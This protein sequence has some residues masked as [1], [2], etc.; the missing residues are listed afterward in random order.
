[1]K[2]VPEE[3]QRQLKTIIDSFDR[4][5]QSVRERQ[6]R[7][8]KKLKLYW[9]GFQR[10]W[11]D[12]SSGDWRVWDDAAAQSDTNDAAYY[13]KPVNVFRA[14]L[15]SIIAALSINLPSVRC[16]PDDADNPLDISTAKAG[17]KIYELVS[18]HNN[19]PLLWLQALYIYCTEGLVFAYN[20][21]KEDKKFGT[22][23]SP[24]YKDEEVNGYYC[25]TCN[26]KIENEVIE[27]NPVNEL[28]MIEEKECPECGSILDPSIEK[29]SIIVSSLV[30]VTENPKSRQF[31]EVYGGLFVKTPTY[32][33][34]QEDMPYLCYSY[35]THYSNVIER[36]PHL[37]DKLG[38]T[39]QPSS[40]GYDSY[41]RWGRLS[42]QYNGEFPQDMVTVRNWWFRPSAFNVLKDERET[43]DLKKRFSKG[44]K[45]VFIND[46][47]AECEEEDL[48]DCWTLLVNPLSDYIQFDPL[49]LLLVSIQDI[50]ND[51]LSL[52]LQTIEQGIP[53]TFADPQVLDFDAYRQQEAT[54]GSVYPTKPVS[55]NK[56]IGESFT[57]LKTATLSQEVMPFGQQV[58]GL[59]QLTSGALPSLFGGESSAGS[60]TAS[61][62]AMSRS[63][64]LQRLQNTWKMFTFW[65]K[66]IFG[67]VIPNYI[68]EVAEDERVVE[69]DK[70]GNFFN[71]YIRKAELQGKIG[72]VTLEA[73]EQ[74]PITWA[75][76]RDIIKE[77]FTLNLPGVMEALSAPENLPIVKEA[78]GLD[79]FVMPGE[80]DRQKQYEEI[81]LL[82]ASQPIS[83][84][85]LDP[86]TGM[87]TE[88]QVPSVEIDPDVDNHEV[89]ASICRSWLIS[90]AGR[91]AK[92]EN[93]PG[94]LNV[95]LHMKEH[96][97]VITQRMMQEQEQ[98]MAMQANAAGSKSSQGNSD[99]SSGEKSEKKLKMPTK[100]VAAQSGESDGSRQ[101]VQ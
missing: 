88:I 10:V 81:Q 70:S 72:E 41:E 2:E 19:A 47:Y 9:N 29:S 3:I 82:L 34:R 77:L 22:Y 67:K 1:M 36:Y 58:Q 16:I 74:L 90:D 84:P 53:Q 4:E 21:T 8:Y 6:I 27:N 99:S 37:R 56:N 33:R 96:I 46:V 87:P 40:G 80:D 68:S 38:P 39:V 85:S 30:G 24:E 50:T 75:Q 59:G 60:K 57:T 20:Y 62:Y 15:E 79:E 73:S 49:G 61:E 28:G 23:E 18:K 55:A 100:Q 17:N 95:L 93:P 31:I 48:D 69:T 101:I 89:E 35:E 51:L 44:V 92:T 25:P 94:Y 86:M 12:T 32:A 65:W 63:Q 78:F 43:D 42:T 66:D 91:L 54:P 5:D 14:Y 13:D 76:K 71:T 64:A 11:W 97:A 52:T 26:N 45:V 83:Q 7:L 98:M